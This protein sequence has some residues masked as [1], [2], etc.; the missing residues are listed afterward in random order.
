MSE[1]T[2]F[3][4]GSP[5]VAMRQSNAGLICLVLIFF[6]YPTPVQVET[7]TPSFDSALA[8]KLIG[9]EATDDALDLT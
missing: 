7:L 2:L 5:G 1:L 9:P 6:Q 4:A 8:R 3:A